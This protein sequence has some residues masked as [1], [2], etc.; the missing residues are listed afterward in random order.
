MMRDR[1]LVINE[2]VS[3]RKRL[4]EISKHH[5]E[6]LNT[7]RTNDDAYYSRPRYEENNL[8]AGT[9]STC[10]A[11][12]S[13][14]E[15][16]KPL[17]KIR[18][19]LDDKQKKIFEKFKDDLLKEDPTSWWYS[20]FDN[21]YDSYTTPFLLLFLI[22]YYRLDE[23]TKETNIC[24][25]FDNQYVIVALSQ[26]IKNFQNNEQPGVI[27]FSSKHDV[28]GFLSYWNFLVLLKLYR[29]APTSMDLSKF[30]N[31]D[32]K[33]N[34]ENR[35]IIFQDQD[36][37]QNNDGEFIISPSSFP[38][39]NN[40]QKTLESVFNWTKSE[41]YKQSTHFHNN[42]N[43]EADPVRSIFCLRIYD[44]FYASYEKGYLP[45]ASPPVY[46]KEYVNT[47]ITDIFK[48]QQ[49]FGL[50]KKYLPILAIPSN[51]G[52]AYPFALISLYQLLIMTDPKG[53]TID[54]FINS[55][56]DAVRWI[57]HMRRTEIR[58][59]GSPMGKFSGWRN[60]LSS[61]PTGHPEC[62]STSL[63]YSS[64]FEIIKILDKQITIETLEYFSRTYNDKN[65]ACGF[66]SIPD[67][68]FEMG[69]KTYSFKKTMMS[70]ITSRLD[71][72]KENWGELPNSVLLHGPPGT[73]KSSIARSIASS[74]GWSFLRID[75][76]DLL[77]QGIANAPK[78][79]SQ[80]FSMLENTTKTVILFD[81]IDECIRDRSDPNVSLENRLLTNMLLTKLND[82]ADNKKIIYFV[83]TNNLCDID[84]A[85]RRE[86]RFD[87]IIYLDYYFN[88]TIH[89]NFTNISSSTDD[90][91]IYH[92]NSLL[93]DIFIKINPSTLSNL[94][95]TRGILYSILSLVKKDATKEE[96]NTIMDRFASSQEEDKCENHSIKTPSKMSRI[97]S[98]VNLDEI[99]INKDNPTF[100]DYK[101]EFNKRKINVDDCEQKIFNG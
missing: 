95:L 10:F 91:K 13:M 101:T 11:L 97:H 76:S 43:D 28:S 16:P 63:V 17:D 31:F 58:F 79:I 61:N 26:I 74:L 67:S 15:S 39:K 56:K 50:W 19:K 47:I 68:I 24:N 48:K 8:K 3:L 37:T 38:T 92:P 34:S 83:A 62:W 80:V 70:I 54:L 12:L 69:N 82:L 41:L 85:I 86:G 64:I 4:I 36:P 57:E 52:N 29:Y 33:Q 93:S 60:P 71:S 6:D 32:M 14:L 42:L 78:S 5:L 66:M 75:T 25:L 73:G 46:N 35:H 22:R 9:T 7:Y 40:I 84:E 94:P 98:S 81:E 44:Q 27:R 20:Y 55:I 18:S 49:D 100:I 53:D 87:F 77:H 51:D 90:W 88:K 99:V 1:L 2:Y 30:T 72:Q 59:D 21:P 96:I 45:F 65:N 89:H 23:S